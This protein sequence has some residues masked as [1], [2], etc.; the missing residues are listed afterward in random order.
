MS[1]FF[2]FF[3]KG[4]SDQGICE[5]DSSDVGPNFKQ[6]AFF[7][8]AFGVLEPDFFGA[9]DVASGQATLFMPRLPQEYAVWMGHIETCEEAKERCVLCIMGLQVFRKKSFF[10]YFFFFQIPSR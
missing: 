8:W 10:I 5:G 1:Y 9:I 4:G 6:E 3:F 7:H 2:L